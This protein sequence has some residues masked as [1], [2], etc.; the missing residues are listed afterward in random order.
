[1]LSSKH[2]IGI[3]GYMLVYSI[4]SRQSFEVIRT[5]R[6]KVLNNLVS[7]SSPYMTETTPPRS[8]PRKHIDNSQGAEWVPMVVVGNK[9]DLRPDQRLVSVEEGKKLADEFKCGFVEAS[10]RMDTN[11][12][13]AFEKIIAE[14]EKG[15]KPDEPTGGGKC[16]L[17]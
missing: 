13:Q 8:A 1:M 14:I 5:L 6:E 12:A 11:V 2:V 10:A 3:H 17:M 7:L 4:A 16:S 9:N 15:A